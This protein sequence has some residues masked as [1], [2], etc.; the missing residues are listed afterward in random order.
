MTG[1]KA[2]TW[3]R[4]K[5]R[6]DRVLEYSSVS[7]SHRCPVDPLRICWQTFLCGPGGSTL[8][9]AWVPGMATGTTWLHWTWISMSCM[10][11]VWPHQCH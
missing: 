2:R 7:A 9:S 8:Y 11:Q 3:R 1:K 6:K 10:T 4:T 5:L